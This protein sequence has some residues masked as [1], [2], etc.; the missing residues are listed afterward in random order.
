MRT[1]TL[2]LLMT[3]APVPGTAEEST[4]FESGPDRVHLLELYTSEGCSSC[5][6]ADRWLTGLKED[7]R[8]WD[9]LIP[10]AFHVDYWNYL[11]WPDRFASPA[12]SQRQRDLARAGS[13][14]V[15][16]PGFVLDGREWRRGLF[17]RSLDLR[18]DEHAGQLQLSWSEPWAEITYANEQLEAETLFAHVVHLAFNQSTPIRAGENEGKLLYHDFVV[19]AHE[20]IELESDQGAYSGW[21]K[22]PAIRG[23]ALAAWVNSDRHLMPLQATG[24]WLD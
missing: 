21:V 20:T 13:F 6:P 19:I 5:P 9:Q 4:V 23:T 22:M 3:V 17:D 1:V 16:T 10:V 18:G 15:Y 24:G 11:G 8:L 2:L 12:N 7:N 14:Q